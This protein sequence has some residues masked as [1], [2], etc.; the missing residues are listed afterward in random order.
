MKTGHY[1]GQKQNE[2]IGPG[3]FLIVDLLWS[4]SLETY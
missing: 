2:F 3:I 4:N 1:D